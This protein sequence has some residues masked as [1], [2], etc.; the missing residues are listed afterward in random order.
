MNTPIDPLLEA[1][2]S[3]TAFV[4]PTFEYRV[5]Y[6]L[7]TT[8]CIYKTINDDE[9]DN[10][11]V[12]TPEEYEAINFCPLYS[13]KKGKL[14]L[15]PVDFSSKKMLQLHTS[16]TATLKDHIMFIAGPDDLVDFWEPCANI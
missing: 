11:I 8:E 5:Y 7:A 1:M 16:G 10:F 12:V 6:D 2:Q 4:M 13:V 9:G 15:K 14:H 3:M